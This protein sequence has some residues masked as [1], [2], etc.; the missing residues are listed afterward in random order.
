M[1]GSFQEER[2]EEPCD[3]GLVTPLHSL[4]P[5]VIAFHEWGNLIRDVRDATTWS[6]RLRAAFG[7]PGDV[8]EAKLLATRSMTKGSPGSTDNSGATSQEIKRSAA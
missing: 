8:A 4:N 6:E 3:Y 2:D 7:R 5:F 1:F